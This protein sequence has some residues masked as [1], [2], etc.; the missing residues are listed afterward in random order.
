MTTR[1]TDE[2][3]TEARPF[4]ADIHLSRI[5]AS[6]GGYDASWRFD[7]KTGRLLGSR[8]EAKYRLDVSYA[9]TDAQGRGT[10]E[11]FNIDHH[12]QTTVDLLDE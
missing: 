8:I 6:E 3:R 9:I 2:W 1:P 12:T 4:E 5:V 11:V 10:F 7:R